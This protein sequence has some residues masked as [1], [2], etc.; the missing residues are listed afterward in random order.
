MFR[1]FHN[2][3]LILENHYN[4]LRKDSVLMQCTVYRT[5][6]TSGGWQYYVIAGYLKL[7]KKMEMAGKYYDSRNVSHKN[8]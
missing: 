2:Y 4:V 6:S 1:I 8:L 7:I 5:K 3:Y